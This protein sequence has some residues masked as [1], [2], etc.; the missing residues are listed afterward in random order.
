M[1]GRDVWWKKEI[2]WQRKGK[3]KEYERERKIYIDERENEWN[4]MKYWE[5][6]V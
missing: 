3:K 4:E 5:Y 2:K 6:E 1:N